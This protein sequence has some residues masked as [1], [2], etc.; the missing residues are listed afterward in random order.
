[1]IIIVYYI[2]KQKGKNQKKPRQ[3]QALCKQVFV[4]NE[5]LGWE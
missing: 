1:M 5:Q 3:T 4:C 2:Q